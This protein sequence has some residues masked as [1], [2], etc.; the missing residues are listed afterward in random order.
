MSDADKRRLA[1]ACDEMEQY[2][3]KVVIGPARLAAMNK[4]V[5]ERIKVTSLNYKDID[6]EFEIIGDLPGG[7]TTRAP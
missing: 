5:G 7:R 2:P 6:L 4:K 1:A 3:N